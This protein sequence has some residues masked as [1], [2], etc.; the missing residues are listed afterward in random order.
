MLTRWRLHTVDD[1]RLMRHIISQGRVTRKEARDLFPFCTKG[2]VHYALDKLHKQK[3]V[4]KYTGTG[5]ALVYRRKGT[6]SQATIDEIVSSA[7]EY[8][9]TIRLDK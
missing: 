4:G 7:S 5:R 9:K 8:L 3:R 1:K 6:S 2:Q